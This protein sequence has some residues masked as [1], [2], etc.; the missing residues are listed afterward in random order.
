MRYSLHLVWLSVLL[1]LG[2]AGCSSTKYNSDYNLSRAALKHSAKGDAVALA[3]TAKPSVET[4]LKQE[5]DEGKLEKKRK[6]KAS[7]RY[8]MG[9]KV[10]KG[11]VK[12]GG[13]GDREVVETFTYLA[14]HED[15]NPY[16]PEKYYYDTRKRKLYKT[17][18]ELD[19][20]RHKVLHG[21]YK[22][23]LGG[24]VVE[25]GYFYI[26]TKHLRWERY[27]KNGILLAKE[28]Y[29]KGFQRDAV[30][31]YYGDTKK[32]KEVIPYAYG[33]VQGT[34]YRFYENGH[35]E[36]SGQYEKGR[37]VGIWVK[38]YDFRNRRH[39]EFQYPKSA[40]DPP[41]EPYLVKQYDRHGTLV[42]EKDKLDKRASSR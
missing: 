37:K 11:F 13:R 32:I 35:L 28:H 16:A 9:A 33:E 39:A 7:K 20:E 23:M 17:R 22:K 24:E 1:V 42:Y 34:Y 2:L 4:A 40:Y 27:N 19:P 6:K 5:E 8:F 3:D 15:P 29:D 18:G 41:A 31:T 12:S 38:H 10:S 21:P 25:E 30:V 36:W 14:Q 26:G